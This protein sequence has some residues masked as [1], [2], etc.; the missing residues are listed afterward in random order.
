MPRYCR[1]GGVRVHTV[2]G[3][4]NSY[5]FFGFGGENFEEALAKAEE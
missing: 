3:A 1:K 4:G 2:K 5:K